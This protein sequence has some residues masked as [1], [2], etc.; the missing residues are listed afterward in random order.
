M[1][2]V[3]SLQFFALCLTIVFDSEILEFITHFI[4]LQPTADVADMLLCDM[5]GTVCI[6]ILTYTP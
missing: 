1:Y 4:L 3:I 5:T 6:V 2:E